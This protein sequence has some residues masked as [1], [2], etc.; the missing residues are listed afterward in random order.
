MFCSFLCQL[1]EWSSF[2][3]ILCAIPSLA[4]K[5]IGQFRRGAQNLIKMGY[6]WRQRR[7]QLLVAFLAI[8]SLA[9]SSP[10]GSMAF[11]MRFFRRTLLTATVGGAAPRQASAQLP[12]LDIPPPP[13][14]AAVPSDA[15]VTP[16]GLAFKVLRPPACTSEST[17]KDQRP[18]K[19]DKVTVDYTGWQTDGRMFDSSVKRGQRATFGVSQVIKGWTEGLQLMA[20]GEKRRFWIPADLAYGENPGGGRPGG[21][22]VFDVDLYSVER[23]PRLPTP[24]DVA[25]PP[26]DAEVTTSG[27]ASKVI[28]ASDQSNPKPKSTSKVTVDYTGWTTDGRLF[29]S[30]V[31]RGR[32]ATFRLDQVIPGWTEGVQLMV[33]GEKRRFWI[34]SALAYGDKPSGGKPA[35]MLVFDITLYDFQ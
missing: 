18:L 31:L 35:G 33:S 28:K 21:S 23:G 34:P 26:K 30:S 32:P 2:K 12:F 6:K 8:A 16:S 24:E 29:D 5:S 7:P 11:S 17:C 3:V 10:H 27:I 15:Q 4:T 22:L 13:D 9:F 19:F 20:P 14:V 25:S 1:S